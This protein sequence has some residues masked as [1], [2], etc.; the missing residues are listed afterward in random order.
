M[1]SSGKYLEIRSTS[2]SK[3]R[4]L[5]GTISNSQEAFDCISWTRVS[6]AVMDAELKLHKR[7]LVM[8]ESLLPQQHAAYLFG[9]PDKMSESQYQT[10]YKEKILE[11]K[12]R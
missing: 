9:K 3:N 5:M 8:F 11:T 10:A 6:V 1:S 12:S 4:D 7:Q 2:T